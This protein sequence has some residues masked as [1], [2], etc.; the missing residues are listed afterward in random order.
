VVAP[1]WT[2]RTL[3]SVRGWLDRNARSVAAV[4]VVLLALSLLRNGIAGLTG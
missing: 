3:Q 2:K 1:G 4:I